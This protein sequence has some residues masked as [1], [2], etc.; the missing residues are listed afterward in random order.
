[1]N[2]FSVALAFS[3]GLLAAV[4][5][6]GFAM[7]PTFVAT[8]LGVDTPRAEQRP[9]LRRVL[10]G[11]AVGA[12]VMIGFMAIFA[13]IGAVISLTGQVIARQFPVIVVVLSVLLIGLGAWTSAGRPLPFTVPAPARAPRARGLRGALLYGALYGVVS[14]GCTLPVFLVVVGSSFAQRSVAPGLL[15]FIV[16]SAGM[17]LVVIALAVATALMRDLVRR[18]LRASLRY[19]QRASGLLLSAAGTYLLVREINVPRPGTPGWL[20]DLES[21]NV[22]AVLAPVVAFAAAVLATRVRSAPEGS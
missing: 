19:V 4:N 10:E 13:V 7:L 6:C 20:R 15:L 1:M 22:V 17:G 12:A 14:L 18:A 8:Y 9:N 11:L 21:G 5:P 3:A 2:G 16:Y